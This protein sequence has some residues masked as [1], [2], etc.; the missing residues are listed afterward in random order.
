MQVQ[1]LLA[2]SFGFQAVLH[3]VSQCRGYTYNKFLSIYAENSRN[4][5]KSIGW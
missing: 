1:Y 2:K 4:K 5:L 3:F